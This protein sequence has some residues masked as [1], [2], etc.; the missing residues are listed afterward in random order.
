MRMQISL[1][2]PGVT[3]TS[4]GQLGG[5]PGMP[6]T[7]TLGVETTMHASTPS[8]TT[9]TTPGMSPTG[10]PKT[11]PLPPPWS[12][13]SQSPGRASAGVKGPPSLVTPRIFLPTGGLPASLK[14]ST[15]VA[16]AQTLTDQCL[17]GLLDLQAICLLVRAPGEARLFGVD[18]NFPLRYVLSLSNGAAHWLCCRAVLSAMRRTEG[19]HAT[20][21]Q[22]TEISAFI[23]CVHVTGEQ[24]R[25]PTKI[26]KRD[27]LSEAV[28]PNDYPAPAIP[29]S[30]SQ[31]PQAPR[32]MQDHG[33]GGRG[34]EGLPQPAPA[35]STI[36][37]GPSAIA[38]AQTP[39]G[40]AAAAA[41]QA[42]MAGP[43]PA[44][45]TA[46]PKY[47]P[48]GTLLHQPPPEQRHD[49]S[50][51]QQHQQ[52]QGVSS[53]DALASAGIH[54]GPNRSSSQQSLNQPRL[55]GPPEPALSQADPRLP[56]PQGGPR[57]QMPFPD[58]R[59]HPQHGGMGPHPTP[60]QQITAQAARHE[61]QRVHQNQAAGNGGPPSNMMQFG[62]MQPVPS[63]PKNEGGQPMPNPLQFG[64]PAGMLPGAGLDGR[65]ASASGQ[66]QPGHSQRQ[67]QSV[68]QGRQGSAEGPWQPEDVE[69]QREF[70][71]QR[72]VQRAQ[73]Q[74]STSLYL[75]MTVQSI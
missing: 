44:P 51:H 28:S 72:A 54:H 70:M 17:K 58:T 36:M 9:S 26:L 29:S 18:D 37:K 8:A 52:Q 20:C 11:R 33:E 43:L 1:T 4:Q 19:H 66:G 13:V 48:P 25:G 69:T 65:A 10:V 50:F 22:S 75:F 64:I 53:I 40:A 12:P 68:Q 61:P 56:Y 63:Q 62:S 73:V 16:W 41:A 59:V 55:Q 30:S 46:A 57:P 21:L 74:L 42:A 71:R 67:G 47:N 3:Q 32:S 6:I 39:A 24:A 49:R 14:S 31:A 5:T 35:S 34:P 7:Q 27:P 38:T 45:R 2:Q 23:I 15:V 60:S